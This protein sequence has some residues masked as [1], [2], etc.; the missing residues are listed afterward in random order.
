VETQAKSVLNSVQGMA[1]RWSVNPYRG[2][3]HGCHYCFARRYHRYLDLGTGEDFTGVILVKLNAVTVL[4]AEL[5]PP[6]GSARRSRWGRRPIPTSRSR[7]AT[8]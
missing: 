2:C 3:V 6:A 1:F 7:A 5:S 4:R 8:A